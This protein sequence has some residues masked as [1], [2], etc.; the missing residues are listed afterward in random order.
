MRFWDALLHAVETGRHWIEPFIPGALGAAVGQA[1]EPGLSLKQRLVQWAVG[2]TVAVFIVPALGHAFSWS[3]PIVSAVGFV[4]GTLAF[5][6][7]PAL[8][9]AFMDGATGALRSL[10]EIARSWFRKPGAPAESEKEEPEG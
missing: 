4:V 2:L 3:Q 9:E 5:K 10:P 1:W 7:V 6:A 8:R